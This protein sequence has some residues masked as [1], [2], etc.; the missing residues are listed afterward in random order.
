MPPLRI[1]FAGTPEFSL[2]ALDALAASAHHLVGVLTQPDRPA[3]RGRTLRASPVKERALQL[4]LPVSQPQ[5]LKD[6]SE[7]SVLREW[8]AELL[9]VVAYGLLLP[10]ALLELPRLGCLNIH[11]SLLP[12]WRGAAPIPRAILAGDSESGVSIMQLDA[13]LDTGPVYAQK[14]VAIGAQMS[15]GQLQSILAR[16]GAALLLEVIAERVAGR[17]SAKAQ[18]AEGITYAHKLSKSEA[19]IDWAREAEDIARQ[20]RGCNPWPVAQ[21]TLG[22]EPLKIWKAR[23]Q[24]AGPSAGG[25]PGSVLGI[26]GGRLI[27]ACGAGEL[28]IEEL[29]RAGRRIISAADFAHGQPIAGLRLG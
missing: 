4:T 3:G 10:P 8:K 12:R 28:T 29:Q 5:R 18:P 24:S 26:E 9:V 17:A 2:P 14:K 7:L 15:S 20:V 13:G 25:T 1:A 22:A 11:A 27:V 6:A 23:A 19:P 21:T 16:E